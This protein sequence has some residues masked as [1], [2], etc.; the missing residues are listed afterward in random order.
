MS[1]TSIVKVNPNEDILELVIKTDGKQETY[2]LLTR[3]SDTSVLVVQSEKEILQT[4]SIEKVVLNLKN[5]G[6]LMYLAFNALSG[7]P[8]IQ[9][10][11]SDLQRGFYEACTVCITTVQGFVTKS[12]DVIDLIF[13]AYS[14]LYQLE[15]EAAIDMIS[16][17]GEMAKEMAADARALANRF[18]KIMA[19][20]T[21]VH[22]ESLEL[23]NLK[24][25]DREKLKQGLAELAALQKNA[26]TLQEQ[27]KDSL[28]KI[29]Q[30]YE[31]AKQI[32]AKESQ[33]AFDLGLASTIMGGLGA[34]VGGAVQIFATVKT[35]GL[36]GAIGS[37]TTSGGNTQTSTSNQTVNKVESSIGELEKATKEEL[38]V[39]KQKLKVEEEITECN[40]NIKD[41]PD[42]AGKEAEKQKLQQKT[43]ERE[44]L[45]RDLEKAKLALEAVQQAAD[46]MSQDL[47][48]MS[49]NSQSALERASVHKMNLFN[50][51]NKLA[52]DSRKTMAKLAEYAVRVSNTKIDID[53]TAMAIESLECAV[54]ALA[55]AHVALNETALFWDSMANFCERLQSPQ[56]QKALQS[57]MKIKSPE[58]RRNAYSK[59]A[60]MGSALDLLCRW[61]ALNSVSVKYLKV[62]NEVF[63]KVGSNIASAPSI[64]AGQKAA[65]VLAQSILTNLSAEIQF[66][67][68]QATPVPRQ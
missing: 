2:S 52:E 6:D 30:E 10:K 25:E 21:V 41:L 24:N 26:D 5:T 7:V 34:A 48:Q 16:Q 54:R 19:D 18:K 58:S 15:E 43:Q 63:Q 62:S 60:F 40:K 67:E 55:Q 1:Q 29:N 59:P 14:F 61:V 66:L 50:A 42:G 11:M 36:A 68:V 28:E 64:A 3:P 46:R 65:P 38:A 13:Q 4:L 57:S 49:S 17:C 35:G 56:A 53:N 8:K 23:R 22:N 20:C 27:I 39:Q 9:V 33:R 44:K 31:E 45:A 12:N 37:A 47:K 51:R 32:E